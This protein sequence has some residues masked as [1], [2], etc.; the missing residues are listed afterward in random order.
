VR[1]VLDGW[2]IAGIWSLRSGK[3][4]SLLTGFDDIGSGNVNDRPNLLPGKTERTLK[5]SR[6]LERSEWFDTSAYCENA[7]QSVQLAGGAPACPAGAGVSG[8][9]GTVRENSLD[10]PGYK[11]V[12]AS[13]FRDFKINERVKFQLRGEST[14]VFNFVNLGT[15]G[16][17]L[18]SKQYQGL[19]STAGV[20][21]TAQIT[22]PGSNASMRVIQV[23]GR[24]L[25]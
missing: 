24:L 15:P 22:N 21:S 23:G 7:P 4:F 2:S 18:Y 8:L 25:F 5:G 19:L 12:D 10:A 20:I 6:A 3:P 14:N 17:T 11:D 9:D 16:A 13:L 1:T